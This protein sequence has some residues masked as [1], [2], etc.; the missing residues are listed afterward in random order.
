MKRALLVCLAALVLSACQTTINPSESYYTTPEVSTRAQVERCRVLE[1]RHVSIGATPVQAR[2][3]NYGRPQVQVEEALGGT[4]GAILGALIGSQLGSGDGKV[5]A[6]S[7]GA[8][9]G[10]AAGR[11]YGSQAAQ[12][13]QTKAG[14]EYSILAGS[15]REEIIVQHVNPGDRIVRPGETCRI[16]QSA[17]GLRVLPGEH[18]P[19]QIAR[20]RR[21]TFHQ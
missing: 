10:A 14:V 1:V 12:K 2:G 8:A 16:A 17:Q 13:R 6:T 5:I 3:M 19:T 21:T 9:L 7:L 20:P 4:G 15:G 18:L 11:H